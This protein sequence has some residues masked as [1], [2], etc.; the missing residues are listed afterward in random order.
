MGKSMPV[1]RERGQ[2]FRAL[3][4]H[5]STNTFLSVDKSRVSEWGAGLFFAAAAAE[6]AA[7]LSSHGGVELLE[8]SL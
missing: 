4:Q 7:G 1:L 5:T 2:Y 8:P 3:L 6:S